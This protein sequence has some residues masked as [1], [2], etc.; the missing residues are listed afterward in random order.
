MTKEIGFIGGGQMGEALVKG[1]LKAGLYQAQSI[2]LTDP[3]AGRRSY[4]ES[5]YGIE[6]CDTALPVWQSCGIV[7]LAVKPQIMAE[8]LT[9]AKKQILATHLLITIDELIDRSRAYDT[10]AWCRKSHF[11][12][13]SQK[14]TS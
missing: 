4:L 3:N 5:T 11:S 1:L 12:E 14:R 6:T 13:S 9:S 2:F 10:S 7:I 8:V